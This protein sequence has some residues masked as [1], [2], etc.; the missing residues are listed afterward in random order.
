MYPEKPLDEI[1]YKAGD[2]PLETSPYFDTG[3]YLK[4][5]NDYSQNLW[6]QG[7]VRQRIFFKDNPKSAPALNKTPLV[8]WK[9]GQAFNSSAHT[10]LPRHLNVTYSKEATPEAC[11]ALLHFKFTDLILDKIE[12]EIVR[13]QHYAA[14]REYKAYADFSSSRRLWN[15]KSSL[16]KNWQQLERLGLMS[17]GDWV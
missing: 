10:L 3:N 15:D 12:E 9:T 17:R 16:Y 5:M 4:R 8:R 6:V 1:T 2:N 14:S 7:G 11:G 13:K